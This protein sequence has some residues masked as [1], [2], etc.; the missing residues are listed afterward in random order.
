MIKLFSGYDR[1]KNREIMRFRNPDSIAEMISHC[2]ANCHIWFKANDGTARQCKV[3]GAVKTWKRDANRVEV[4]IK[5]GMYEY[6]TF[7]TRD[8]ERI[9]IPV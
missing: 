4:P 8:I 1:R 7:E 9:L 3:N 2:N 5:Y 6:G